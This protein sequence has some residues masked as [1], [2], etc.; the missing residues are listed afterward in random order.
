V[1]MADGTA[2]LLYNERTQWWVEALYD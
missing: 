2:R 1:V